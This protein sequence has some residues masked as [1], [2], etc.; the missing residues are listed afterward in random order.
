LWD[1][2]RFFDTGRVDAVRF[3]EQ[4]SAIAPS[5]GRQRVLDFGC[6][7]GRVTRALAGYFEEVV[8]V[9]ASRSMIEKA[10]RLNTAY[11][12]CRFVLNRAP[13]LEQFPSARF[14]V[15]YSRL[16]LQHLPPASVRRYVP[17]LVRLLTPGGCLMFQLPDVICRDPE[18]LYRAAP[19]AGTR[20]KRA[21]PAW[22]V[23][24]Y[25]R[26]KYRVVLRHS[27]ER[28][29]MF[30]LPQ[31]E[32]EVLIQR[33]GGRLLATRTDQS[34]GLPTPGFEYWISR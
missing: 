19:V 34:H 21:A 24:L 23:Q 5:A 9:D 2:E 22:L 8:G 20:W 33:A 16:V 28:M 13:H 15:V 18:D 1:L 25:R 30:G 29:E 10:R 4:L 31:H 11:P 12:R 14:D 6:G 3:V 26:Y 7:V 27:L 17:E 32:V